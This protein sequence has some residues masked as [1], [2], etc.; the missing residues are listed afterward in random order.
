M[1]STKQPIKRITTIELTLVEAA[2]ALKYKDWDSTNEYLDADSHDDVYH[3][4]YGKKDVTYFSEILPGANAIFPLEVAIATE[5]AERDAYAGAISKAR[6][7][8]IKISL[9]NISDI[10]CEYLGQ[11]SEGNQLPVS[12]KAGIKEVSV[13]VPENKV[14]V[15]IENP[16]HLINGLIDAMGYFYPTEIY[17]DIPRNDR[18]IK[19]YFLGNI[20]FAFEVFEIRKD[21]GELSSQFSPDV[22]KEFLKSELKYRIQELNPNDVAERIID[23]VENER[24]G[25]AKEAIDLACELTGMTKIQ[26]KAALRDSSKSMVRDVS[27]KM[28]K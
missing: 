18:D 5:D 26:I 25:S 27:K 10:Q 22:D 6:H 14:L 21:A 28:K 3:S 24:I 1:G 19:N 17:A 20:G 12:I 9:E 15:T 2:N 4:G 16:E 7:E 8:A 23:A 11:D 13:D